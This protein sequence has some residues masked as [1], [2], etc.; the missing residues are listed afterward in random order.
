[1]KWRRAS[2]IPVFLRGKKRFGKPWKGSFWKT[3]CKLSISFIMSHWTMSRLHETPL[4]KEL[5]TQKM[6]LKQPYLIVIQKQRNFLKPVSISKVKQQ[7]ILQTTWIKIELQKRNCKIT[8][9]EDALDS[10]KCWKISWSEDNTLS[11]EK[12]KGN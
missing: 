10:V 2:P 5:D 7:E 6:E 1:M 3:L 8:V 11:K 4:T 12:E 9:S